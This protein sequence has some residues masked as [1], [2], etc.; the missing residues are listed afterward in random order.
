MNP[1]IQ[2][3]NRPQHRPP[4]S[5]PGLCIPRTREPASL[6][7][8]AFGPD[9]A[10]LARI[11]HGGSDE[12][13]VVVHTADG[14]RTWHRRRLPVPEA[15]AAGGVYLDIRHEADGRLL[16]VPAEP[17]QERI[18]VAFATTDG[19]RTWE[20]LAAFPLHQAAAGD[21][22]PASRHL[23]GIAFVDAFTGWIT[24]QVHGDGPYHQGVPST[25]PAR[26]LPGGL[27]TS[28]TSSAP[29]SCPWAA[30]HPPGGRTSCAPWRFRA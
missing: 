13:L 23:T 25:S 20:R 26:R 2:P 11:P 17:A 8:Q 10:W 30:Q 1:A 19:G 27:K 12:A 18:A 7:G 6:V 4:P 24:A 22:F 16:V 14:G 29:P 15:G 3:P 5:G 9:H 28:P 21:A